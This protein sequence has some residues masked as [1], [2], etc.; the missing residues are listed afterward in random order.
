MDIQINNRLEAFLYWKATGIK[1]EGWDLTPRNKEEEYLAATCER[2]DEIAGGGPTP[3][4]PG[5]NDYADYI[6]KPIELMPEATT[7]N[8]NDSTVD[9]VAGDLFYVDNTK[10]IDMELY[11]KGLI[12]D[13]DSGM[14]MMGH[15]LLGN[16]LTMAN[17]S[18]IAVKI[19]GEL[20]E[21]DHEVYILEFVQD[22]NTQAGIKFL[23]STDACTIAQMDVMQGFQNL[24]ANGNIEIVHSST[25]EV[26]DAIKNIDLFGISFITLEEGLYY[27][28]EAG[29]DFYNVGDSLNDLYFN[30]EQLAAMLPTLIYASSSE[31]S[32]IWPGY[33]VEYCILMGID[34]SGASAYPAM[35]AWHDKTNDKYLITFEGYMIWLYIE[36]GFAGIDTSDP[37]TIATYALEMDG[38]WVLNQKPFGPSGEAIPITYN[39]FIMQGRSIAEMNFTIASLRVLNAFYN[40]VSA[41]IGKVVDGNFVPIQV[42]EASVNLYQHN[43]KLSKNDRFLTFAIYNSSAASL[44]ARDIYTYLKQNGYSVT[45]DFYSNNEFYGAAG[46]NNYCGIAVYAYNDYF[47]TISHSGTTFYNGMWSIDEVT[48]IDN[49][50]QI[51]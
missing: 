28:Q 22:N 33:D 49:V 43:I 3:P 9:F 48:I 30:Q 2:I 21:K 19:P 25:V 46:S 44:T 1:P 26:S 45:S 35:M 20:V 11:L 24:D 47:D 6:N 15:C 42:G 5:S 12:Y 17:N 34:M 4:P 10:P 16:I 38:N 39:P 31:T 8:F 50:L 36:S 27:K 32:E 37:E 14:G 23:Y 40:L 51:N 7:I 29:K 18:L 13:F 41:K